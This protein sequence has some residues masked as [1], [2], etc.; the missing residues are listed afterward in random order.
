M[1]Q[2]ANAFLTKKYTGI[3]QIP[4]RT[5]E[6]KSKW[7]KPLLVLQSEDSDFEIEK[8][9]RSNGWNIVSW[10]NNVLQLSGVSNAEGTFGSHP[11]QSKGTPSN[12]NN[13]GAIGCLIIFGIILIAF[14][15]CSVSFSK[16]VSDNANKP[17]TSTA[18][19][20]EVMCEEFV[21]K[22]LNAP[23]TAKFSRQN[24]KADDE[25]PNKY[26]V[27][28]FVEAENRLGGTVGTQYR[29]DISYDPATDL[30]TADTFLDE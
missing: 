30:W 5:I 29:C 19:G 28:G 20:A 23:S 3:N 17:K 1:N 21:K 9:L 26:I 18:I 14:I 24:P 10:K 15:S 2:V 11:S 8:T 25:I 7:G 16:S 12:K 6:I 4:M 22:K 13:A 27:T